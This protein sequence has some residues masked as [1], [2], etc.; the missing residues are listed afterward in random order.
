MMSMPFRS[1][2]SLLSIILLSEFS[3]SQDNPSSFDEI[4]K[5]D[6]VMRVSIENFAFPGGVIYAQYKDSVIL[7]KA[8]GY[9][10]YDSVVAVE[11]DHIYD[12]ASVT[13]VTA[14]TLALMKLYD[15]GLIHLDDKV[16]KYFP[17]IKGERG[18]VSIRSILAHQSGW[19]SWIPYHM[20]IRDKQGRLK[21]KF[22]ASEKSE[23]YDFELSPGKYLR[24]DFY[25]YIKK[26]ISKAEF[27]P[28]QG[29]VY[30]GMFF[31]LVPELVQKLVGIPFW[32]YLQDNFYTP[33]GATSLG[34]NPLERFALSEIVPTE[35]DTFFREVPIHGFVHDEGA[36]M[37]RGVSGNAGLFS[38][39]A[40]LA[41]VWS[42]FLNR[43][44]VQDST[45]LQEQTVDL[46]TTAQFP[47][48]NNRRGLGF[49][50]PLLEY[51]SLKSSVAYSASARS[52]G[53][54]GYTGPLVWA[55]PDKELLFIFL[56]NRVYP[57]RNHRMIYELNVRPTLHQLIY[58]MVDNQ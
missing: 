45:Y 40:D 55:D 37:M 50:K 31:Y 32:K 23:K 28:S 15:N 12:L 53:H 49:D 17:R 42:L 13:K 29:Y 41:K 39:A 43:G 8:Y 26:M 57:T 38:N 2:F 24:S 16:S 48:N 14:A 25:K 46:F 22:V 34:F 20:E 4:G 27:D 51:D 33:V 35:V 3:Y 44:S 5:I 10:T 36:I 47:N 19:R 6:S 21:Q 1:L 56:S 9:H 52:Y 18:K 30:S 54:S 11:E 58:D 7:H